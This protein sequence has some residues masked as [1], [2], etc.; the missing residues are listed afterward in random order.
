MVETMNNIVFKCGRCKSAVKAPVGSIG[1][2]GICPNCGHLVKVP[3]R[4]SVVDAERIKT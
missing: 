1:C 4:K 2:L 3:K